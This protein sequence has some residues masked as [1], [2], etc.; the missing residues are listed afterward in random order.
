[1]V[2]LDRHHLA[3]ALTLAMVAGFVDAVAFVELGGFFVSFMSGNSTRLGVGVI[4]QA[5]AW[6]LAGALIL[7]FLGGV[8]SGSLLGRRIGVRR[9]R[10]ILAAVAALLGSAALLA[11]AGHGIAAALAMATAMGMEN[12][13][14]ERDGAMPFGLTYM[15]GAVVRV[16]QLLAARLSGARA[17]GMGHFAALWLALLLGAIAGAAAHMAVGMAA[18]WLATG[19]AA[20]AAIGAPETKPL[21]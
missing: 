12:T 4:E 17:D 21:A 1:M 16:G 18:L 14:F 3:L 20:L 8:T 10:V 5:R 11:A 9:A 15:T 19:V 2:G 6:Q 13:V 7:A